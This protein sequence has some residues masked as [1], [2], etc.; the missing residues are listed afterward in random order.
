MQPSYTLYAWL[1][2]RPYNAPKT[3]SQ[4][5]RRLFGHLGFRSLGSSKVDV[6]VFIKSQK[7][8]VEI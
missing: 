1:G 5:E 6:K 2:T 7:F 3:A 4:G 8:K